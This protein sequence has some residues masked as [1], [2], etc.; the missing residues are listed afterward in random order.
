MAIPRQGFDSNS[1][2]RTQG[3]GESDKWFQWAL[4]PGGDAVQ[5]YLTD[6]DARQAQINDFNFIDPMQRSLTRDA[7]LAG[8]QDAYIN[9]LQAQAEGRGVP[10]LAQMQ[11]ARAL[12]QVQSQ[13]AGSM[14]A[15]R[16]L[17]PALAARLVGQQQA[18]ASQMAA[19]QG[20]MLR[21]QE[22]MNA[23]QMLGQTLA[24]VRGQDQS[25]FGA[26]ASGNQGQN[27]LQSQNFNAQQQLNAQTEENNRQAMERA[28]R[29][30]MGLDAQR[31]Q[32]V[33]DAAGGILET[34]AQ[35]AFPK[36]KPPGANSGAIVLGAPSVMGDHEANDTVLAR[37][38]PGEVVVPRSVVLS[39]DAPER[40]AAFVSRM[41]N[42]AESD[43][44]M[45]RALY[46]DAPAGDDALRRS[47]L[48][49]AQR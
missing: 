35:V 40:A 2:V 20:A 4:G 43:P 41:K 37:L 46:G 18:Q 5:S 33:R 10:S 12:N 26:G 17:N 28:Q 45:R 1:G 3:T 9:T 14:A 11:L 13:A 38:S 24:G 49:Y 6:A 44:S 21:A 25:M 23:Q 34:G 42:E 29:D 16:G 8:Q 39:P 19:G 27:A 36:P 7:R 47:L 48:S 22:Q 31:A 15:T 32:S 30:R